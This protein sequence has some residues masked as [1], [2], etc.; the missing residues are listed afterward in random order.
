MKRLRNT[1]TA[2]L[3]EPKKPTRRQRKVRDRTTRKLQKKHKK[4]IKRHKKQC[5]R[6]Q[7]RQDS[8]KIEQHIMWLLLPSKHWKEL[9]LLSKKP[10]MQELRLFKNYQKV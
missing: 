5:T 8:S 6:P 2:L 1:K 7:L 9:D 3:K 10:A 4:P